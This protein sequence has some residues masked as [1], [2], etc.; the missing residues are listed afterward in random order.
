MSQFK[1]T[2]SITVA[3]FDLEPSDL[4][5]TRQFSGDTERYANMESE[6]GSMVIALD[7]LEDESTTQQWLGREVMS[8]VQKLRK[9]GNLSVRKN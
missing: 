2:G 4:T 1:K 6:D 3:G 7:L 8:A 9:T 5:V